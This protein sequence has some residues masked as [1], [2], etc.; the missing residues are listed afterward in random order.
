MILL[1]TSH[2]VG[3]LYACIYMSP[4][5]LKLP[6]HWHCMTQYILA[7]HRFVLH[8]FV[9]SNLAIACIISHNKM[10]Q[11]LSYILFYNEIKMVCC[12]GIVYYQ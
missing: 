10:F 5:Q 7:T 2:F 9:Q 1:Q 3:T 4:E 12:V 6:S 8:R 11:M